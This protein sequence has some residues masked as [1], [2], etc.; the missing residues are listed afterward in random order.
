MSDNKITDLYEADGHLFIMASVSGNELAVC[1]R[2]PRGRSAIETQELKTGTWLG[3]NAPIA[4]TQSGSLVFDALNTWRMK[5]GVDPI[6]D[7][8]I[9]VDMGLMEG[10]D[11]GKREPW[12]EDPDAWKKG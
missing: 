9:M 1:V 5:E 6:T 2:N 7:I 12:E 4:L 3:V 10:E 11:Q 8:L